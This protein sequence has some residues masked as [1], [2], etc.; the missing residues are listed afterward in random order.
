LQQIICRPSSRR[1]QLPNA[2]ELR[3]LWALTL[4]NIFDLTV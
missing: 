3:R 4:T 1:R 2:I